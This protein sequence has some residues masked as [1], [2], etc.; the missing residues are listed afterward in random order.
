MSLRR[1]VVGTGAVILVTASFFF[2]QAPFQAWATDWAK[3]EAEQK[4][5]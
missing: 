3:W 2:V 1:A 4:V 5:K